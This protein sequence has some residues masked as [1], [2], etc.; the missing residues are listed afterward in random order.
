MFYEGIL[1]AEIMD[2]DDVEKRI[3]DEEDYIRAP[4]F[5][6]SLVKFMAKAKDQ[7]NIEDALIAKVLMMSEEEVQK[8]YDEAVAM[9]KEGVSDE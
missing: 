6:N 8:I 2:R 1:G 5:G 3:R 7:E 9:L 4:K